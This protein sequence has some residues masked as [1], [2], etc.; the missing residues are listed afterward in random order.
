MNMKKLS[1]VICT[2][3][4][5]ISIFLKC[6][7]AIKIASKKHLPFEVI[8]IDNNSTNHFQKN[9][10]IKEL[11]TDLGIK[12]FIETKQGLTP[13]RIKGI[14]KSSGDIILFVDDDNFINED[15][16]LEGFKIAM[17]FP[18]IGSWSG[19]VNL[20]F[21]SSPPEWSFKYHGLLVQR[22]ILKDIWSN[23]SQINETM[24]CGAGLFVRRNVAEY[25]VK[26]HD[27]GQRQIQLDRSVNSLFS[28]GD[29]DLAA[30][31]C[32][33]GLGIGLF[34]NLNLTHFIPTFRLR[35]N[36][37]LQL[38]TGISA[39]AIVLNYY[40]GQK[41]KKRNLKNKIGS[42]LRILLMNNIECKFYKAHLKGEKLGLMLLKKYEINPYS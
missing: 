6:L 12:Y 33:L 31:A 25:Y 30:C 29:N 21:E 28:G 16:L 19:N 32:D 3:N 22:K 13:A 38:T 42:L 35:L 2:Y 7:E 1:I 27:S 8:I 24:P 37:L 10:F 20:E 5:S 34:H 26:L 23:S 11:I 41:Y 14:N 39:S 4:P 15:F 18:F 36:Y 17:N 9:E 40:R